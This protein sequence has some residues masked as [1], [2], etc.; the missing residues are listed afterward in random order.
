MIDRKSSWIDIIKRYKRKKISVRILFKYPHLPNPM[1]RSG[2]IL[3]TSF[4]NF[5]MDDP[6]VGVSYYAYNY[7]IEISEVRV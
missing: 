3:T 6:I 7:I 5:S 1:I 2:R 4:D